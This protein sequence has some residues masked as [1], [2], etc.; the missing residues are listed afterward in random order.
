MP[1]E[2]E[3]ILPAQDYD[4]HRFAAGKIFVAMDT[5]VFALGDLAANGFSIIDLTAIGAQIVPAAVGIFGDHAIGGADEARFV[6]LV[7]PRHR[8]FQNVDGVAFD[9]VFENGAVIDIARRQ[10]PQ[11][12]HARV[13]A[14]DN[15]N[16]AR[17]L[18]RQPERERD[19]FDRRELAVKRAEAFGVT[20]H[21]VEQDRRRGAAALFGEHVGDGAH[22]DVP[23]RAGDALELAEP[24]DR[25][26][27]AA[28]P[29]IALRGRDIRR[30][31]ASHLAR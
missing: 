20:G 15:V 21:V 27:P 16:F 25:V 13:I 6:A 22:L 4:F 24:I 18:Q 8:K 19:A 30:L 26:D 23:M 5:S 14:L 12:L 2:Q 11:I 17:V 9:H 29:A 7:V 31:V 3:R 10:R 28:Q 1:H